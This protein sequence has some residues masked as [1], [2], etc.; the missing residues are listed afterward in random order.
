MV[1]LFTHP[2]LP[3]RELA[4]PAT[5]ALAG[6]LCLTASVAA[7]VTLAALVRCTFLCPR[8]ERRPLSRPPKSA[9]LQAHHAAL[10]WFAAALLA[11]PFNAAASTG[12]PIGYVLGDPWSYLT[13][14]QS[15]QAWS[16]TAAGAG[17]VSVVT[18]IKRR[19]PSAVAMTVLGVLLALPT[20]V[21]AQVSVGVDHDFATDAATVFTLFTVIWF[22]TSWV[23][24]GPQARTDPAIRARAATI[25]RIGLPIALGC[26]I[27]IAAYELAG[28][29]PLRSAYGVGVLLLLALLVGFG[30]LTVRRPAR[31]AGGVSGRFDGLVRP[32]VILVL[33]V[34]ATLVLLNAPRYTAPQTTT[35]NFLGYDL[36]RPPELATMASP[37]R[38]NLLITLLA[39]TAIA[40]YL[41]GFVRLRRRGD[42]WPLHRL[43]LWTAGWVVVLG[44]S[45][46]RLWMYSS[47]SF[48]WHMAAHMSLNMLAPPL[49]VL[50]GP[51]TLALRALPAGRG[52]L[53]SLREALAALIGASWLQ[54]LL[55]PLLIWVVF[56]GSFYLLYFT[57]LFGYAMRFHWA[58]QLMTLHFLIIGC[59]FY[60]IAIGLDR[61]VRDVPP[62]ARLAVIF[63]A[64]PFHAFFAVAVLAGDG[65][66]IGAHYYRLLDLGWL[67]DLAAQQRLGGEIAWATGELPLLVV[68][69]ALV[70]Q[71]FGT[72]Q[73][74]ARR[75]DRQADRDGE[76]ELGAYNDLLAELAR[77]QDGRRDHSDDNSDNSDDSHDN[78]DDSRDN[79]RSLT[80]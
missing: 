33:G 78:S 35:E 59:E 8:P 74:L 10:V 66:P 76:A 27:G 1:W 38:P 30:A 36:P 24:A 17:V 55:N 19:W 32:L 23:A 22:A 13:A 15:T 63:A 46:T 62:V 11:V 16:A 25:A 67:N 70:A 61:P 52:E 42:D 49:L 71:W 44:V 69:V 12:V 64:M 18:L 14:V 20:V 68:I 60:G 53:P 39:L 54:R 47:A 4:D 72:E 48:A 75:R 6:G 57:P 43:L 37:G 45:T 51:I 31:T 28:G 50:G 34:Q 9:W 26:R 77:R 40:L 5:V 80:R 73:R 29:S 41:W 58:H 79:D 56:V 7:L 2:Q 65:D 3:G 21:T